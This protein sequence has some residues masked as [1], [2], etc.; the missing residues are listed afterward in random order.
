[1]STGVYE[2]TMEDPNRNEG[3]LNMP[4]SVDTPLAI[5]FYL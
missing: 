5:R 3:V 2:L 1:M 4:G